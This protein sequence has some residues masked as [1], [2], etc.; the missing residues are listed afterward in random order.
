MY[1]TNKIMIMEDRINNI[2]N[3]TAYIHQHTFKCVKV[4]DDVVIL[5]YQNT[6][7]K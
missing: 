7:Y 2:L 3:K 1:Y 4:D 5:V 6:P